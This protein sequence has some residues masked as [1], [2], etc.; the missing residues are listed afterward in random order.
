MDS[1]ALFDIFGTSQMLT[2]CWTLD[3]LFI[4]DMFFESTQTNPH[5]FLKNII[6]GSMR[7]KSVGLFWTE[8]VCVFRTLFLLWFEM[9]NVL[10]EELICNQQKCHQLDETDPSAPSGASLL[11]YYFEQHFSILTFC[12]V[13]GGGGHR[14]SKSGGL[15]RLSWGHASGHCPLHTLK[16]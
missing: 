1:D 5:L 15:V 2:K 7:N 3:P 8:C 16:R 4:T 11:T 9:F 10:A 13:Q 6:L 14:P 12:G